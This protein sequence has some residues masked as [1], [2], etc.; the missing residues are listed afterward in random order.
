VT[1]TNVYRE[2]VLVLDYHRLREL[3]RELATEQ[4]GPRK[5][6]FALGIVTKPLDVGNVAYEFE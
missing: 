6:A 1:R 3:S 4:C 2:A 5:L